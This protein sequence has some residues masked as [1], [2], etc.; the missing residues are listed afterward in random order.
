MAA[1]VALTWTGCGARNEAAPVAAA[2]PVAVQA[3]VW[4]IEPRTFTASVAV[5]GTLVSKSQV[6]VKAETTGRVLRFDKQEGDQVRAGEALVWV[7]EENYKL[8]VA[9][10]ESAV[11]VAEASLER[12]SV[13]ESH[14]RSEHERARNLVAS[15]GITDK[16]LQS[17]AIAEKDAV[18]QVTLAK[19]QL[20]QSR[21][22]LE[23]ARKRLRDSVVKAPVSGEIQK[24]YVNP[25]AY[26]EPP[27]PVFSL[28]DNTRLE[29]ESPVA[30][31]ELAPIRRGQRVTFEVNSYPAVKFEGVVEE[32]NPA[33]DAASRSAKVRVR[34]NNAGGRLKAGMF[35]QGE[36]LTGVSA[37]AVIIPATAVY[38]EDRS[39]KQSTVFVVENERAVRRGVRIGRERDGELE[40]LEG[41][42]PGDAL[43]TEQSIE[44]AEGVRV[45][46]Q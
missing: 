19:A 22:V 23:Q 13:L 21:S 26:V 37:Q 5:T 2:E 36:I 29:L 15:G 14:S 40:I 34:V 25:G 9:Q 38:R 11:G 7:D 4:K 16:D 20:A 27:T 32:I 30:T 6:D 43:I 35:A 44:L 12:A 28:V 3:R 24:K 1:A 10:A 18:A 41:L 39:S 42:K 17:A 31:A 8:A 33:V 45:R 46:A